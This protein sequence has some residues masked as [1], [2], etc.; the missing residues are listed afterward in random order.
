[1]INPSNPGRFDPKVFVNCAQD[2]GV[3][4]EVAIYNIRGIYNKDSLVY[5][6]IFLYVY[7]HHHHDSI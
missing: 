7:L 4:W 2:K 6:F 5:L 1:M 3:R